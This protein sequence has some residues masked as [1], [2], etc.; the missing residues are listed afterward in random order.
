MKKKITAIVLCLGMGSTLLAGC[1][2]TP[3]ESIVREKGADSID[4]YESGEDIKGALHI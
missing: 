4:K 2:K 3:K 1:E